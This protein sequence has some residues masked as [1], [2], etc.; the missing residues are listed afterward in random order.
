M[1]KRFEEQSGRKAIHD[2]L[3]GYACVEVLVAA[4]E[5]AGTLN[6]ERVA[7]ALSTLEITTV[8]GKVK[9][10]GLA[11]LRWRPLHSNDKMGCSR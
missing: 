1:V 9:F 6:R 2:F 3:S 5:K 4:I 10:N 11:T 8:I 7:E